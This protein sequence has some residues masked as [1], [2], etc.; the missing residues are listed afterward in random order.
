MWI[1]FLGYGEEKPWVTWVQALG[2][3]RCAKNAILDETSGGLP[4]LRKHLQ[5]HAWFLI[6]L[7]GPQDKP[8]LYDDSAETH[9]RL[10][11]VVAP[12]VLTTLADQGLE[13][14]VLGDS[15]F[16]QSWWRLLNLNQDTP[17]RRSRSSPS[18]AV[19]ADMLCG[20]DVVFGNSDAVVIRNSDAVVMVIRNS[21]AVVMVIRNSDAVV[22]VI[23]NSDDVVMV[24]RNS[25]SDAFVMVVRGCHGLMAASE[26]KW[27]CGGGTSIF[28]IGHNI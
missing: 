9:A 6:A 10:K 13:L 18:F 27:L 12:N 25:D 5:V 17:Q 4:N 2:K 26:P 21:D 7:N 11:F 24:I 22:M 8:C 3:S 16:P 20:D 23:R 14:M 15:G 28:N 1:E 19:L